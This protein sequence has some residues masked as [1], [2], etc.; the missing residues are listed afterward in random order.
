MDFELYM[1]FGFVRKYKHVLYIKRIYNSCIGDIYWLLYNCA[2]KTG[3]TN[4]HVVK[5]YPKL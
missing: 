3:V 1:K 2:Q 4:L 5:I